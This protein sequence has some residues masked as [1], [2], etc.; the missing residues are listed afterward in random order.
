MPRREGACVVRSR[1]RHPV[2]APGRR[3]LGPAA[4]AGD[5]AAA[6]LAAVD[7]DSLDPEAGSPPVP[8]DGSSDLEKRLGGARVLGQEPA[9]LADRQPASIRADVEFAAQRVR[10]VRGS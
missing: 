2:A 6:R 1:A 4:G 10:R 7:L 8:G 3:A 9:T 5:H